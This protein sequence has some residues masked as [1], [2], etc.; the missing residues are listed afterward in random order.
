MIALL[1]E[2]SHY[3]Q[4]KKYHLHK[5]TKF[6]NVFFSHTTDEIID[7]F[8]TILLLYYCCHPK[9]QQY[10]GHSELRT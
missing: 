5:S 3:I 1:T 8:F 7:F 2:Y 9:Q 10:V 6:V 4:E